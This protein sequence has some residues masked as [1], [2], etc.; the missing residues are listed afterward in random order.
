MYNENQFASRDKAL[1]RK[2]N[3]CSSDNFESAPVA[4]KY[5]VD[6]SASCC[7][8]NVVIYLVNLSF[9]THTGFSHKTILSYARPEVDALTTT[10]VG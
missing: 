6:T 8:C 9:D 2:F 5:A 3:N 1:F 7:G 4:N 10:C